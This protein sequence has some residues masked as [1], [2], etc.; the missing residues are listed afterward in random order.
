[1]RKDAKVLK[2]VKDPAHIAGYYENGGH[3]GHTY[4][5]EGFKV[6]KYFKSDRFELLDEN[7]KRKNGEPM[8]GIGLEVETTCNTIDDSDVLAEVID[9]M[10]FSHFPEDLWKFQKD[11]SLSGHSSVECITQVMTIAFIR[12]HYK[13][14]KL[15][16]DHYFKH[17]GIKCNSSC[18]M[19]TNMSN[20]LFGKTQ[21]AQEEAIR[22]LFYIV[23]RWYEITCP[24]FNR[25][26]D[27]T[28]YCR[29]MN[30]E[31]AKTMD[32]HSFC[33]NHGVCFNLGHIDEGR[34][35]LRLVGPQTSFGCFR[36]TMEC[37]FFL[38]NR[39][40]T[41]KWED[42]DDVYKIFQG[43]NQYV[44]DRLRTKCNLLQE[45]LDNIRQKIKYDDF[46]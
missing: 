22:K 44:Y 41:I 43:C 27:A 32:L 19:H 17:L 35:E 5:Y 8:Q 10:V 2:T 33:S 12:N 31:D 38:I 11:G 21:E 9:K 14:F 39:V 40:R 20:A 28:Q 46:I 16:Y 34:I 24:L 4:Q 36:N 23:N 42:C 1:M 25:R 37:V 7:F 3:S 13:D 29:R 26:I 30:Y 6:N 45:T 18:G 15:M